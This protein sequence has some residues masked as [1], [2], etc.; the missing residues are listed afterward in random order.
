VKLTL[1]S[2]QPWHVRSAI[3]NLEAHQVQMN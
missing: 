1:G 2:E 3:E